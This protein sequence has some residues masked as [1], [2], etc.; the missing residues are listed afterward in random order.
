MDGLC[1][2]L[3]ILA[4]TGFAVC[5]GLSFCSASTEELAIGMICVLLPYLWFNASP[6]SMLMGDAGSRAL[7]LFLAMI[8]LR[9]GYVLLYIP[10]CLIFLLDGGLGLLK[11]ALLRSVKIHILKNTRTPLHDHARK[12]KGWSDTQ[13][14]LRFAIIQAL[15]LIVTVTA[16]WSCK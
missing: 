13:T 4:L 1:T 10:F 14:V 11:L 8:A 7:G 2:T 6:S 15:I 12:N 9:S 5:G 16:L 3:S